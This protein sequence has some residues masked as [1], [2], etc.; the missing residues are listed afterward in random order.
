MVITYTGDLEKIAEGKGPKRV[1]VKAAI[2]Y[3]VGK[4]S[5]CYLPIVNKSTTMVTTGKW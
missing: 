5:K 2:D 1:H 4:T 3:V